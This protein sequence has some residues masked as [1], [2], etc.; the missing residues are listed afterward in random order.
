MKRTS[1]IFTAPRQVIVQSEELP[2][3]PAD[4]VLVAAHC[5]AIS[6]GTELLIYRDQ[7]PA[8]METDAMFSALDDKLTYPL[9]YGYSMV[10]EVIEVGAEVDPDWQGKLVFA[11]NPHESH[12]QARPVDLIRLPTGMTAEDAISLPNMETAVNFVMD[13]SPRLGEKVAV[14]GQG[15]VGL[16][17]TALLS[18]H[19]IVSLVTFDCYDLRRMTALSLGAGYS[20]D[21]MAADALDRARAVWNETDYAG[22]D[23]IYELSGNPLALDQAISLAGFAG[24]VVIGSWY[25]NKRSDLNL[26]G[27]FHRKRVQLISSQVST[28]T[29]ALHGRWSRAR[30][31]AVAWEMLQRVKPARFITQRFSLADAQQA[32]QLLDERPQEAI[33]VVLTY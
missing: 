19:P 27:A 15:I 29:P 7:M 20:L 11:F 10:G 2:E 30:R 12:F 8:K 31:F 6:S 21:P 18:M 24:R 33:Q 5:S 9:K 3:L 13:G 4:Q 25:G 23:L 22:A 14:F 17:T 16:L 28:L 32:Y 26:G 1:L